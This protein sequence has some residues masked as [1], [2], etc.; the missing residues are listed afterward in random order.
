MN[1]GGSWNNDARNC[2][3]ANRNNN[4]PGNEN[5]NLG[6]RAAL[7]F[8]GPLTSGCFN[9]DMGTFRAKIPHKHTYEKPVE[10]QHRRLTGVTLQFFCK[11][12]HC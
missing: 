6:F 3:S 8:F 5:N 7:G 12:Q 10:S 9:L 1:R 4:G 11:R 2:R